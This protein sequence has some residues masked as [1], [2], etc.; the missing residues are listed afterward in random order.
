MPYSMIFGGDQ[1]AAVFSHT[2]D[3][4]M[5]RFM[6]AVWTPSCFDFFQDSILS[7]K[8]KQEAFS[9]ANFHA[10]EKAHSHLA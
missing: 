4:H 3:A 1:D 9:N 2:S 7:D 5:I 10:F 6:V 8:L